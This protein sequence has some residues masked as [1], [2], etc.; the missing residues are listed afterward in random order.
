[1]NTSVLGKLSYKA[2][3]TPEYVDGVNYIEI[4]NPKTP[5][6]MFLNPL[7]KRVIST[8]FGDAHSIRRLMDFIS[9]PD[10]PAEFLTKKLSH[11]D[12]E[13]IKSF[14]YK[15]VKHYWVFILYFLIIRVRSDGEL[16]RML[17]ENTLPICGT[18]TQKETSKVTNKEIVNRRHVHSLLGY[19]GCIRVVQELIKLNKLRDDKYIK[20]YLD[21]E[22]GDFE[23]LYTNLYDDIMS[24]DHKVGMLRA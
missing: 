19:V 10:Y 13:D 6:G 7:H 17:H 23:K 21:A 2:D 4:I 5:L 18:S 14:K 15:H 9:K 12:I 3:V 8:E 24:R 11:K 16:I 1:M 20:K 22:V